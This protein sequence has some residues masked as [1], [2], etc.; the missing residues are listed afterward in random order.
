MVTRPACP[1]GYPRDSNLS[2]APR[3]RIDL[4][5]PQ[6]NSFGWRAAFPWL[7]RK[8]DRIELHP[9]LPAISLEP[10]ISDA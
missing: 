5:R 8:K 6:F 2:M 9:F 4:G 1:R 3:H 7:P 10:R